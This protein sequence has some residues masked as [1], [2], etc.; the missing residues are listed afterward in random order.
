MSKNQVVFEIDLCWINCVAAIEVLRFEEGYCWTGRFPDGSERCSHS[1]LTVSI[2]CFGLLKDGALQ[3]CMVCSRFGEDGNVCGSEKGSE[4]WRG[5]CVSDGRIEICQV[6]TVGKVL[7][8]FSCR[9]RVVCEGLV[10][11]Y[12]RSGFRRATGCVGTGFSF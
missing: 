4:I 8:E 3:F 5:T 6:K 9:L 12:E 11:L 1:F 7:L 10:V 2:D